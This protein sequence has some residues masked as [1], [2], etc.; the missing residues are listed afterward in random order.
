MMSRSWS[1][2]TIRPDGTAAEVEDMAATDPRVRRSPPARKGGAGAR[3]A[4]TGFKEALSL[5]ADYVVEM[6]GDFSHQPQFIP[7]APGRGQD[8]DLVLGSRFVKGGKDA[9][10]AFSGA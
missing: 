2:T 1:W 10:R 9:D 7:D 8:R 4:S 5:G 3:P 6:D